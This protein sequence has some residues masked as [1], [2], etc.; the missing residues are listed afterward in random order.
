[1]A[2]SKG[3]KTLPIKAQQRILATQNVRIARKKWGVAAEQ[4]AVLR[5]LT[6]ELQLSVT[7]GDL[8]LLDGKWYVTH[9]GLLRIARRRRCSGI[10]VH[11]LTIPVKTAAPLP[12]SDGRSSCRA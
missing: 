6:K 2:R 7:L 10:R 12:P 4:I 11:V 9:A 3:P 5:A 8:R 1:M